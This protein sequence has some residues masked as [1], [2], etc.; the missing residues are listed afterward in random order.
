MP[1]VEEAITVNAPVERVFSEW[2]DYER[3][4]TFM[5][6][7]KEVRRTGPG[8]TH[9]TVR[10]AG[11]QLEWDARTIAEDEEHVAWIAEGDSGQSG[12]VKFLPVGPDKTRIDVKM[13]YTLPS[14]LTEA[15][16]DVFRF[17][18]RTVK[19][20]LE[21]FKENIEKKAL[22]AVASEEG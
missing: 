6:N 2:T 14:A 22:G 8:R 3:F 21:R 20:D 17:D 11:R 16:A 13:N 18:E 7:V 1:T 5:E 19:R 15:V 10:A 4:P 12:E 9:W